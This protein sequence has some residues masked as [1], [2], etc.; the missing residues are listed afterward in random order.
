MKNN[1]WGWVI[2]MWIVLLWSCS[3]PNSEKDDAQENSA[4]LCNDK[5]D[6]DEDGAIDCQDAECTPFCPPDAGV[7]T[8]SGTD[9]D[10]DTEIDVLDH[11]I[12]SANEI[13]LRLAN[14]FSLRSLPFDSVANLP[15]DGYKTACEWYG[16]LGVASLTEN[17]QLLSSLVSKFDPL[18]PNF[19]GDITS[20][21]AHVD[22]YVFGMVPLE[23]YLKTNDESYLS[24][25]TEVADT[26][27]VTN[28]TRNAVDDMFMMTGLQIQAYRATGDEK[29]TNFMAQ[30]MVDYLGAQQPNGLFFHNVTQAPVHWGRGN[31]WFAAG[32]AEIMRDL[33]QNHPNYGAIE[34]GYLRMMAGLLQYQGSNGMWFQVID[35]PSDP[36][37]WEE[38][39]C[40]AMFTYAMVAGV[41]RGVLDADTY[42]P[43]IEKAWEGLQSKITANGDARD[44]CV[45]TWYK[46]SPQEYMGLTRLTGDGHGQAPVIWTAAEILR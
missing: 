42:V 20:G 3:D 25:G 38:S 8:S 13:G 16:S 22:R 26:Q 29:Y 27:Q 14:R 44:V 17:Q 24:L 7:D 30:T 5:V 2:S 35:M 19:V 39:S 4:A 18:K 32:M 45:G 9:S 23:I 46:N 43:V 21:D 33:P 11:L 41:K 34:A 31:G 6:N 10:T 37:N 15:G 12:P 40:T 36:N 1:F 28:Q